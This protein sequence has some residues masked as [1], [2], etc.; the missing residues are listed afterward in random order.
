MRDCGGLAEHQWNRGLFVKV[1]IASCV[2]YADAWKP[3]MALLRRFWPDCPYEV[4]FVTDA[5]TPGRSWCRVLTDFASTQ[6][7]PVLLMQEDFFLSAPVNTLLVEL[8]LTLL[9]TRKAAMVRLYPCPG[10]NEDIGVPYFGRIRRGTPY[11]VS[12]QASIWR[13][14]V[15]AEIASHGETPSDFEILGSAVSNRMAAE[16]LAFDRES[17]PWPM[18]YF[19]SAISRG[20]WN[21]QALAHCRKHGIPVDTSLR[22]TATA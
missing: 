19:C 13:P 15:L 10:S 5:D 9:E 18:E 4:H 14:D 11:R 21:P 22:E 2:A 1:A 6:K 7:D 17:Q 8:A 3:C 20:Q 12:C 16:F